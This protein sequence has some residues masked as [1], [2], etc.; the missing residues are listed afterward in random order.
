MASD[1]QILQKNLGHYRPYGENSWI[2]RKDPDFVESEMSHTDAL[3]SQLATQTG[4]TEAE[5]AAL[6]GRTQ[7]FVNKM[8]R[9]PY[10]METMHVGK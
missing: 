3:C 8:Q 4:G 9:R 6:A 2:N 10:G 5:A 7:V 1:R